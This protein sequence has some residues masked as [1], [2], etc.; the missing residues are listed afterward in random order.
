MSSPENTKI[1]P[2]DNQVS[3]DNAYTTGPFPSVVQTASSVT[4]CIGIFG[5]PQVSIENDLI[6][7]SQSLPCITSI[8]ALTETE[9]KSYVPCTRR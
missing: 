4:S 9:D 2:Q 5:G 8:T 7:I 1:L 3:F 6:G